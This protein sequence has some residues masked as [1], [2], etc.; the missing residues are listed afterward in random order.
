MKDKKFLVLSTVFFLLFLFGI[1]S[2]SLDKPT[3]Q[4][5]RAKNATPS[6]LKS[7]VKFYP[8]TAPVGNNKVTVNVYIRDVSANSLPG[9]TVRLLVPDPKIIISPADT[10]TTNDFGMA[11]FVITSNIVGLFKLSAIDVSSEISISDSNI[12]DIEFTP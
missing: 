8:P 1:I 11:Q 10:Q 4:I 12:P 2:L 9:R 3:S 6:P 5:L 7:F